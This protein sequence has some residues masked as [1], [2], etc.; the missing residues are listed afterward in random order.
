MSLQDRLEPRDPNP[1]AVTPGR[2]TFRYIQMGVYLAFAVGIPTYIYVEG[3][4]RG[5][6]LVLTWLLAFYMAARAVAIYV[7]F[8]QETSPSRYNQAYVEAQDLFPDGDSTPL[9]DAKD[10][11]EPKPPKSDDGKNGSA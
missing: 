9:Q 4:T 5:S 3:R 6:L 8:R 10:T 7:R 2:R 1:P 11:Q